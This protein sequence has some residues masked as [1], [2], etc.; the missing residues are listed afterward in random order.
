MYKHLSDLCSHPLDVAFPWIISAFVT[1]LSLGETLLLWDRIIG[2]DSLLPLPVL[3]VAVIML[4][5]VHVKQP[6][7]MYCFQGL[8]RISYRRCCSGRIM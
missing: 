3:A 6:I 8:E 4:R 7:C 2:F 1:H 5:C